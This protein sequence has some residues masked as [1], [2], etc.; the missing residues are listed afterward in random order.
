[1]TILSFVEVPALPSQ[2]SD[3]CNQSSS[4]E[5]PTFM[6]NV[7][8]GAGAYPRLVVDE[9]VFDTLQKITMV[10]QPTVRGRMRGVLGAPS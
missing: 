7:A 6:T 2:A 10:A 8:K 4:D 9:A 5:D 1:M 3:L